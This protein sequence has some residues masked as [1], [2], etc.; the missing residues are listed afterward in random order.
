MIGSGFRIFGLRRQSG[1]KLEGFG[2]A[3]P[4]LRGAS[5]LSVAA[6]AGRYSGRGR[7]IGV[8]SGVGLVPRTQAP[9]AIAMRATRVES[10]IRLPL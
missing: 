3:L 4:H 7:S 5:L 10:N 9:R 8:K 6:G 1:E 2:A